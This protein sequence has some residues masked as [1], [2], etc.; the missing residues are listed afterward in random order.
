MLEPQVPQM[1]QSNDDLSRDLARDSL[2]MLAAVS[3]AHKW[4]G[5]EWAPLALTLLRELRAQPAGQ[6]RRALCELEAMA[7]H[8]SVCGVKLDARFKRCMEALDDHARRRLSPKER[9]E[10]RAALDQE[11]PSASRAPVLKRL[12]LHSERTYN[13]KAVAWGAAVQVEH[14]LP[15]KLSGE[16]HDSFDEAK[17][18]EWLH[19]VGNLA[20]LA[21][22]RNASVSN[23]PFVV[24]KAKLQGAATGFP[25]SIDSFSEERW[26]VETLARRQKKALRYLIDALQLDQPY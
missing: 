1:G 13:Q 6:L 17:H 12:N 4:S 26:D 16:W 19:R 22:K 3:A 25:L 20:L 24:K 5:V 7:F 14:I 23:S 15:Q 18:A 2:E 8:W 9:E 10:L 11:L 21:G